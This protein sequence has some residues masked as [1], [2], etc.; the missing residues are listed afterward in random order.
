[1]VPEKVSA[2]GLAREE[3]IYVGFNPEFIIM[4]DI[5]GDEPTPGDHLTE[6]LA[7]H[8]IP[9]VAH[10]PRVHPAARE[11][12]TRGALYQANPEL[13][14]AAAVYVRTKGEK[15]EVSSRK[16]LFSSGQWEEQW[17][18]DFNRMHKEHPRSASLAEHADDLHRINSKDPR[19]PVFR[20]LVKHP[21]GLPVTM[22][23]DN[24]R[25]SF[26][27]YVTGSRNIIELVLPIL[28]VGMKKIQ[29]AGFKVFYGID[30]WTDPVLHRLSWGGVIQDVVDKHTPLDGTIEKWLAVASLLGV[31]ADD[32]NPLYLPAVLTVE[33]PG[34]IAPEQRKHALAHMVESVA[35]PAM[36]QLFPQACR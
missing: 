7:E 26:Y 16:P 29:S 6:Y 13:P 1:M 27:L 8:A 36:E 17:A 18:V 24:A 9:H 34:K 2:I 4:T 33:F 21:I 35:L 5:H 32:T 31:K 3:S 28:R 14:G 19:V 23:E 10:I 20:E 15:Y 25:D 12:K 30:D 22:H 11:T